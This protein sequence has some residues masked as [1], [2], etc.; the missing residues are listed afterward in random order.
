MFARSILT[1]LA[2]S[3]ALAAPAGA[4]TL[5][6]TTGALLFTAAPGIENDVRVIG[7]AGPPLELEIRTT[8]DPVAYSAENPLPAFCQDADAD[9]AASPATVVRCEGVTAATVDL[10]DLEDQGDTQGDA[11]GL[12]WLGGAGDDRIEGGNGSQTID[13]GAGIDTLYGGAGADVIRGGDG[14]DTLDGETGADDLDGGAGDDFLL[15]E[16][17]ADADVIRG[18]GGA[19]LVAVVADTATDTLDGGGGI[20]TILYAATGPLYIDLSAGKA[21]TAGEADSIGG[22]EDVNQV[23]GHVQAVLYADPNDATVTGDAGVNTISTS[24]GND[25]IDPKAGNDQVNARAGDDVI[26]LRDGFADRVICG[27]GA[28][29]VQADTLD[30]V[31]DDCETVTRTD[32]GN[33]NDAPEDRAPTVSITAPS[34]A[35]VLSTVTPNTITATATDDRGVARVI[36]STGER[37]LCTDTTAPYTCDYRPTSADVGRDTLVVIAVDTAEQ[38]ASAVRVVNVPRFK[39]TSLSAATKPGRDRRAPYT[40]TTKGR[41]ALPAGVLPAAGCKGTV[42]VSFKAGRKTVSSRRVKLK[43]D[44]RYSSKVTFRLPRRLNPKTLAVV[45][46]YG[47]NAVVEGLTARKH[48][49]RTR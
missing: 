9:P 44:C 32:S 8:D 34:S 28:D 42:D 33:A 39:A 43:S 13:G 10:G 38:T 49:V 20:D 24:F 17:P 21:G 11:A 14:A 41:L 25:K 12:T 23:I 27:D 29:T 16:A 7:D 46:I 37:T 40:F 45:V 4:A 1:G 18:G 19:D 6:G 47:G 48:S 2:L 26:E 22:F 3:V 36:F 31:A 5:T 30:V 15:E 35:S